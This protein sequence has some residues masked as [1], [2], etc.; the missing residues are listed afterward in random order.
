MIARAL[1][2]TATLATGALVAASPADA[3]PL[4]YLQALTESGLVV[5]DTAQALRTGYAICAALNTANGAVVADQVYEL[6]D[7]E[8]Y[9]QAA[10]I[11]VVAVEQLCPWH[12]RRGEL[13]RA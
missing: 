13:V 4:T 6:A 12:D 11:V 8:T 5:T 9:E 10:V 1:A 7:V 3:T 2:A